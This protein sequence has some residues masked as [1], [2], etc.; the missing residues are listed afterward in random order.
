MECFAIP[1]GI[2]L[3]CKFRRLAQSQ[4]LAIRNPTFKVT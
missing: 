3:A 4:L 1:Y 2:R